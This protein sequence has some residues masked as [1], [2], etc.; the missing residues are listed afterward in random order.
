MRQ[1][2]AAMGH[3]VGMSD[4]IDNGLPA[5]PRLRASRSTPLPSEPP[6]LSMAAN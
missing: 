2:Q 5:I 6:A 3:A 1:V 4:P